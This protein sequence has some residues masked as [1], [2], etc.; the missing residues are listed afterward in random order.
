MG[1]GCRCSHCSDIVL[2]LDCLIP[3][4]TKTV[5]CTLDNF[6]H[7][8]YLRLNKI[9]GVYCLYKIYDLCLVGVHVDWFL[10]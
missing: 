3:G 5:A 7:V 4:F 1:E 6:L 9:F 8:S 10:L 2:T